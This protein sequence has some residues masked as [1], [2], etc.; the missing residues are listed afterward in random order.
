MKTLDCNKARDDDNF[1]GLQNEIT[2]KANCSIWEWQYV[3]EQAPNESRHEYSQKTISKDN[4]NFRK[5]VTYIYIYNC[6]PYF[7]T[8]FP[9][10]L[11]SAHC[12]MHPL[13]LWAFGFSPLGGLA[14]GFFLRLSKSSLISLVQFYFISFLTQHI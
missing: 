3:D 7:R 9:I 11:T 4:E 8:F 13:F 1:K 5:L 6:I 2:R 10:S 14:V 12:D